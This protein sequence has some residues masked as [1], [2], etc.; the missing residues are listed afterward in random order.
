MIELPSMLVQTV[1]SAASS[2]MGLVSLL[3]QVEINL[4]LKSGL[5]RAGR[6]VDL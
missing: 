1:M 2:V 3:C 4:Q 6:R 5:A